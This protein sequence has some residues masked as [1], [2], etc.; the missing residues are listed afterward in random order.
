MGEV[1]T[2]EVIGKR[3]L[4]IGNIACEL[5]TVDRDELKNISPLEHQALWQNS[6]SRLVDSPVVEIQYE[7][8]L[9]E[10]RWTDILT[11][12]RGCGIFGVHQPLCGRDILSANPEVQQKSLGDTLRS[13]KMAHSIGADYYV[14]HLD[15]VDNWVTEREEVLN[16][17]LGVFSKVALYHHKMGFGHDLC[18]EF[19]L[20]Y[21]KHPST[22]E[23]FQNVLNRILQIYPHTKIIFDVAHHWHNTLLTKNL[24]EN[25]WQRALVNALDQIHFSHPGIIRGFHFGGSY[26]EASTDTHITHGIP[27]FYIDGEY[28]SGSELTLESSPYDFKGHWMN[29]LPTLRVLDDFTKTYYPQGLPVVLEV[30]GLKDK[31]KYT[32]ELTNALYQ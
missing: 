27:G 16:L 1:V 30:Q 31:M 14:T 13:M 25:D 23:D 3:P 5:E 11:R 26:I 9:E 28:V 20:E 21:P 6:L 22:P 8:P 17:A 10:E 4:M 2:N 15:F 29:V 18:V 12:P 19:P 7:G 24:W 32:Q